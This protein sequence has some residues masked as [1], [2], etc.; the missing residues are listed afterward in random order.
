MLYT[1]GHSAAIKKERLFN[2]HGL[3]TVRS[4]KSSLTVAGRP[5]LFPALRH[6]FNPNC[7]QYT[8]EGFAK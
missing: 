6:L 8:W 5:S 4:I 3:K 2:G 7:V 1:A